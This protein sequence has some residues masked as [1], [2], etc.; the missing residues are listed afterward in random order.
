MKLILIRHGQTEWNRA[1]RVQGRTDVAL[2]ETGR[3][4]AEAIARRLAKEKIHGIYSSPLSR[5]KETAGAIAAAQGLP[6]A[7][8]IDGLTEICFGQWEGKNSLELEREFPELWINWNWVLH[9]E[10][11]A[12]IGAESAAEILERALHSLARIGKEHEEKDC[13]AVVSHTMP[14]K[15]ITAHAIG[16]PLTDI[17]ALRLDNCSY[18]ELKLGADLRGSLI[19]WN[20]TVHLAERGLL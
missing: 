7:K 1:R 16:L 11:C 3:L 20:D 15:L 6:K 13:V 4:Q 12:S 8:E 5:A 10:I 2:N 17:R 18:T 19:T 9:P 14:I